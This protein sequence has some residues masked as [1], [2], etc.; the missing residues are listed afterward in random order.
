[1]LADKRVESK[2]SSVCNV[3]SLL[4]RSLCGV[5]MAGA[6]QNLLELFSHQLLIGG[7]LESHTDTLI[8]EA[9]ERVLSISE[10]RDC[11][12]Q[13]V[14]ICRSLSCEIKP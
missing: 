6:D 9:L 1:M 14:N 13:I 8:Q 11:W 3:F 4:Y 12:K 2:Q 10:P 7:L 5:V